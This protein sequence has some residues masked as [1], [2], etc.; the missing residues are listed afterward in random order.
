MLED[1]ML[2]E[3][4]PTRRIRGGGD[5]ELH[6]VEGGNPRGPAILFVHGYCQ[7]TFAWRFQFESDL[8]RDFR[9]VAFDLR[10]HGRSDKP[11]DPK[12]YGDSQM[13]ADDVAAV[14][15]ELG[16]ER[17]VAVCW[18]YAGLV[19]ADYLRIYGANKLGAIDLVGAVTVKGGEKAR[20]FTGPRFAELFPA[21]FSNDATL[22]GPVLERLAEV[23]V[24]P[25]QLDETTRLA[26]IGI[27]A[28]TASAAR[29]G[30]QRGRKLDNDDVLSALDLPVLCTHG[31]QDAVVLPASGEHNAR[32]LLNARL[33][34][35]EGVGHSP[36]WQEPDRFNRELRALAA[37]AFR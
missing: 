2:R 30:M 13:W 18:S 16:L 9:L 1:S 12:A 5:V 23:C 29:E 27:A 32:V 17:P 6:V 34:L 31:V 25:A 36:F 10:G 21:I 14:I 24:V 37:T 22:L 11:E 4:G 15:A 19:I 3:S 7:S 26:L 20:P 35:Y 28:L 33:S 8:A